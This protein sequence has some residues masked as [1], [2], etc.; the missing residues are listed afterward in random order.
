M[1]MRAESAHELERPFATGLG[2]T[3]VLGPTITTGDDIGPVWNPDGSFGWEVGFKT[4]GRNGWIVQ[5]VVT[6]VRAE[7]SN[8][9]S[10]TMPHTPI[11]WEAWNVDDAGVVSPNIGTTNDKFHRP[12][13]R[14]A[15]KGQWSILATCY[16]TL[17]DPVEQGFR[18]GAVPEA[19]S[20]QATRQKPPSLGV[21]RLVRYAQGRFDL[22]GAAPVHTGSA[23]P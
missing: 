5:E 12:T 19:Q 8:G 3:R 22:T 1:A 2:W 20:L 9:A 18:T 7:D 14:I 6:T 16:F 11:Y 23:G 15:V 4:N 17:S 10:V 21:P 13:P